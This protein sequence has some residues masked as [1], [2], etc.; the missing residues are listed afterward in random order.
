MMRLVIT[1]LA[2]VCVAA[3]L[4]SSAL[5][6]EGKAH[7]FSVGEKLEYSIYWGP[8]SVGRASLEVVGKV[9][10]DGQECYHLVAQ[11]KTSGIAE[12]LYPV[13]SKTESW[14][15]VDEL[16]TRKYIQDR[17]EGGHVRKDETVYD[18]TRNLAITSNLVSGVVRETEIDGGVQ[19]VVTAIYYLRTQ[20][21]ELDAKQSLVIN[22][23]KTNYP[24]S[25]QPDSRKPITTRPLGKVSALRIEPSP[26]LHIVSSNGGRMW[27]WVSDDDQHVPLQVVATMKIGSARLVLT[28]VT[29]MKTDSNGGG[30]KEQ[31]A[32]GGPTTNFKSAN[33]ST[34][35]GAK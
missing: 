35:G 21:L 5:A 16:I 34:G 15:D 14:W 10:L 11:A 13:R 23:S 30:S 25:F 33:P 32:A 6:G 28:D 8:F 4:A 22:A 17:S 31:P 7:P 2:R 20:S 26:T 9:N 1:L 27:F 12:S 3:G 18:Y 19:D 29:G 24:V